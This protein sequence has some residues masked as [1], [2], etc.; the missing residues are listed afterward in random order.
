MNELDI[1]KF[2]AHRALNVPNRDPDDDLRTVS[3][4]F[5]KAVEINEKLKAQLEEL[6]RIKSNRD[7]LASKLEELDF[8]SREEALKKQN[9]ALVKDKVE[10]IASASDLIDYDQENQVPVCH[11]C[12]MELSQQ[13]TGHKLSCLAYKILLQPTHLRQAIDK[14]LV[15]TK[16][17]P[18]KRKRKK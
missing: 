7:E 9:E 2:Y 11:C 5:L 18:T 15:L 1:A 16:G 3:R 6:E 17:E 14:A 4:Q 10:L 12:G 8:G 13:G